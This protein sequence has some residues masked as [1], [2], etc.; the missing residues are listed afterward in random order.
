MNGRAEGPPL[1]EGYYV[2]YSVIS[3]SAGTDPMVMS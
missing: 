2:R 3:P 1:G